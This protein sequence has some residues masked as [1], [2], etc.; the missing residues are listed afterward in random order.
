MFIIIIFFNVKILILFVVEN[1]IEVM[2]E[3]YS[4]SFLNYFINIMII[5]FGSVV[6]VCL[7][8]IIL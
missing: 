8:M 6:C 7:L 4:N 5:F 1:G 2:I 3:V